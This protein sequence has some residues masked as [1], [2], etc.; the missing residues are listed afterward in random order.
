LKIKEDEL[1]KLREQKTKAEL[2]ALHSRINPHFLYNALNSLAGLANENAG[3]TEKM[4]LALSKLFR[5][6]INK[7]NETYTTLKEEMEMTRSYLEIEKLRFNDKLD[8]TLDMAPDLEN[9]QVPR[10]LI[11]PLVEN[12]IKHGIAKIT[13][14]GVVNITVKQEDKKLIISVQDNGPDFPDDLLSG[15]GLQSIYDKLDL[16]Y[17]DRYKMR[18]TNGKDKNI[19]IILELDSVQKEN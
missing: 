10:F 2:D 5:Y 15:Y 4:A 17:P 14:K 16:L 3:Q 18:F 9:M 12:S 1:L 8:F 13:K 19:I 6:N 7:E 11:Q